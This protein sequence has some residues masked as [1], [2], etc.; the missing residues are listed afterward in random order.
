V[1]PGKLADEWSGGRSGQFRKPGAPGSV[2]HL[3]PTWDSIRVHFGI[4]D[5]YFSSPAFTVISEPSRTV[6]SRDQSL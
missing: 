1:T 6:I 5:A 4:E 3:D 2:L